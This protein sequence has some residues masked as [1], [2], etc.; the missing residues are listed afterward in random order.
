MKR[1]V[2]LGGGTA[3]TMM[4]NRLVRALPD[5]E[6]TVTVIDRDDRHVYQPGLLFVPF[7][8]YEPGELVRPRRRH[9]D[10]KVGLRLATVEHV[11]PKSHAVVLSSG[12]RVHY[13]V[14]IVATGSRIRPEETPGLTGPGWRKS[15]FDFYTLDGA[16]ELRAAL[17]AFKGGRLVIDVAEMPIKCPVAPLEFAFL[18]DA[19]FRSRGIRDR[20]DIVYA[21]PLEGAFTK[22]RASALLGTM[23]Q[24]RKIEVVGDFA[25]SEV[26]GDKR[27]AKSF[28]GRS[29][30]YDLF[31]TIPL[32]GGDEAIAR[33]GLGDGGGWFP[34]HKHTLQSVHFPDIFAIGDATDLP[35]SKAGAVAHFQS[36][37]LFE[38]VMRFVAGRAPEPAFDGHA[39]CFIETGDGKAM[40]IDFNYETEPLPGR[41]PLPGVGPFT[42]LEE[43]A[44][45]HWGKL[46]FRWLYWNVLLEGK[47]LPMDHRMVLA[48]KW[49]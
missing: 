22:P 18:A 2:V 19:Y 35:A 48:G 16:T 37:V 6:W 21:T 20:V 1:I 24:H 12:D 3:G 44:Q 10:A 25:L 34:T 28:D 13:D 4:A 7:G 11:D 47:P 39:N 23:L 40:L 14:L 8:T 26:D 45:N 33:S 38:N 46:A 43:S 41:F 32:H 49:S 27:V 17:D 31:V 15:A 30:A 29:L 36:D 5:R 42:L 9:L